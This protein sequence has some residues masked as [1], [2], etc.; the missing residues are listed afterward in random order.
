MILVQ[1]ELRN[2]EYVSQKSVIVILQTICG[3]ISKPL[4]LLP[5]KYKWF[6]IFLCLHRK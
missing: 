1:F 2:F 3:D 6:V 5:S 4:R